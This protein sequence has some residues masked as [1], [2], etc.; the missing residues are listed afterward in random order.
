LTGPRFINV[1][2]TVYKEFPIVGERL[3]FELRFEIYN[4]ANRFPAN[5][6]DVSRTS[7]SFGSITTQRPGVFGRQVQYSGRF[8]W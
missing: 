3:K 8:V 2:T 7:P 5:D 1:D 4:V 6:P